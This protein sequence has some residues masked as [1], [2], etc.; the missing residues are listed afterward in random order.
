[1]L[2]SQISKNEKDSINQMKKNSANKKTEENSKESTKNILHIFHALLK[3]W[4]L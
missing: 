3:R 4:T 1:M 2:G